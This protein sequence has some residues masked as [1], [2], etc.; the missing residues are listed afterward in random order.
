MA[1]ETSG[2]VCSVAVFENSSC[3]GY[4]EEKEDFKHA[5]ILTI[6]IEKLLNR[7]DIRPNQLDAI[8]LSGG[9]GSYTGLRIGTST[10][11]GLCYALDK[12][13]LAIDT[14]QII[15]NG[16]VETHK[17]NGLICPMVDARRMEVFTS[18]FDENLKAVTAPKPLILDEN[19][20]KP[21]L[22]NSIIHFV[23]NGS[24]KAADVILHSN[25]RFYSD[26]FLSA[27]NM[28]D[29]A[30]RKLQNQDFADTVY[31]EPF[32]LKEFFMTGKK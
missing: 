28:G 30:L 18:L 29:L 23:G 9:P 14:L 3:F 7:L 1:I 17:K 4:L 27:K 8:A 22:E 6:L 13:L 26:D 2:K 31:F 25:A 24:E 16:F 12:P 5:A 19:S 20:Y 11:K 32:Y 21:E 15:A 10:A